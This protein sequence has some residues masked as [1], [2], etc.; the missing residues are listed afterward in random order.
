MLKLEDNMLE[1]NRAI[2]K[3]EKVTHISW[4]KYNA[5][6]YEVFVYLHGQEDTIYQMVTPDELYE[7][8]QYFIESSENNLSG[9]ET[10]PEMEL[11]RLNT[12]STVENG[13]LTNGYKYVVDLAKVDFITIKENDEDGTYFCKLHLQSKDVRIVVKYYEQVKILIEAWKQYR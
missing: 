9:F 6:K 2:T 12:K 13:I 10:R 3:I 11:E 4:K 1:T 5:N 7:L 8:K